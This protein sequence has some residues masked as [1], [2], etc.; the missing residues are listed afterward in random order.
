[1]HLISKDLISDY[2]TLLRLSRKKSIRMI[3]DD[4]DLQT[5]WTPVFIGVT[6]FY[7]FISVVYQ[8][9]L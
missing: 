7:E 1:M 5:C 3:R 6:T 8:K 9:Y 4:K 2:D